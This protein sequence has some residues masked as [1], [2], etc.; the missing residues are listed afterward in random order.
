M[1]SHL[2]DRTTSNSA[3]KRKGSSS[4]KWIDGGIVV[5]IFIFAA[6]SPHSIAVAQTA[7]ILG[8]LLWVARF[9]FDPRPRLQRT[10]L[11]Y[12][13]LA[14]FIVS[15]L[16]A[17][18][19]YAPIVSIGKMRAASL[20][21][22]VYLVAEN[23]RSLRVARLLALTLIASCMVNVLFTA[24]QMV[25]GRGVKLEGVKLESPLALAVF[26]T[27]R[28]R[29]P[30]PIIDGDTV[31]EVD[32]Q[33]VHDPDELA[34]LLAGAGAAG[35]KT[36]Q[37]KIYRFEWTPTL[38]VPGGHLLAGTTAQQ[39][40]GISG[41]TRGRDWRATGFFSHWVTYAEV[42]QLIAALALGVFLAL[43]SKRGWV[44]LLLVVAVAGLLFA[45][46]LTVTRA[47]WVG[48]LISASLMLLLSASRR[49]IVVVAACAIP[50]V[51]AGLFVLQQKRNIGF[52]DRSDQSTTW[53]ETV[54]R[55]G[56][57]LLISKPRHILVGV[58]MDSI[59]S[60]WREW[61]LFDNGRLPMGHMHSNVLQIALERGV[62]ALIIWLLLLG[63]YARMLWSLLRRTGTSYGAAKETPRE[64]ER[65]NKRSSLLGWIDRSEWL[66]RGIVLGALGGLAGFF[67]SGLVHYNWGD[68]EVVMVFY[69]IM[70][71]TLVVQR[72]REVA[73]SHLPLNTGE[74]FSRK[75]RVP[76]RTSSV[77][78]RDE[79]SSVSSASPSSRES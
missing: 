28:V 37:V 63:L 70:A 54:W 6:F 19:S 31:L 60:H 71:L 62:P 11:D 51:L 23:V 33:R 1:P 73:G 20:F 17:V 3:N 10:P 8:M 24:G 57:D 39:Q 38:E 69:F 68:S 27:R 47:S 76:S 13:L 2:S 44:G 77:A 42:L 30:T 75:A 64:F 26:R 53:R 36:A 74:R 14:F 49:T 22:I 34:A 15:G 7:W 67:A 58:G 52:I 18:F 79:K 61:G 5:F 35:A 9:A 55:E 66:D 16:S 43:P 65:K 59:K 48:F 32:G 21:T 4:S 50:V 46:A 78:N 41:W 45:L 72:E 25:L 12:V 40:L 29:Q 56:F